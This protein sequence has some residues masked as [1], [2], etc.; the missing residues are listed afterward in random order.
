MRI[1]TMLSNCLTTWNIIWIHPQEKCSLPL[2]AHQLLS[3][4]SQTWM[5][6]LHTSAYL[7]LP[8]CLH[9]LCFLMLLHQFR[10]KGFH[11]ELQTD[12]TESQ[13][14]WGWKE[15]LEGPSSLLKQGHRVGCPGLCSDDFWIFLRIEAPQW[16]WAKWARCPHSE[17]V[18]SDI[19]REPPAV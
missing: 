8:A 14:S 15:P 1:L 4:F 19:H 17:K 5:A 6:S 16:L 18:F 3:H 2:L 12:F 9:E 11:L 7:A 13:N 10:C